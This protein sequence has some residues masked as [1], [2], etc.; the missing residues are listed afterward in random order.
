MQS[1]D[2]TNVSVPAERKGLLEAFRFKS[3]GLTVSFASFA[4]MVL[5]YPTTAFTE[6]SGWRGFILGTTCLFLVYA[7]SKM[8]VS[9]TLSKLVGY[10]GDATYG[11]YLLHPVLFF[12]LVQIILPRAGITNPSEWALYARLIF[13]CSVIGLAFWLAL[14]S[15]RHFEKP[16]R[17]Y[18]KPKT[19]TP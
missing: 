13:G 11:L 3:M 16:V 4:F 19:V 9:G 7:A 12:G 14:L 10:F 15:E 17:L 2:K 6:I 5:V 8:S 18:F 1:T